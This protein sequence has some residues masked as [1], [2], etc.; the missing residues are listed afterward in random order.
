MKA[1]FIL[2][3]AI[4]AITL[5]AFIP[6]NFSITGKWKMHHPN[7]PDIFVNFKA[8]NTYT[9]YTVDNKILVTGKY[10]VSNDTFFV[11]DNNCGGDYWGAYK[12]TFFGDDSLAIKLSQ[13]S[14]TGRAEG[15]DGQ[16]AKRITK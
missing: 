13:D 5:M 8:D 6:A 3:F 7:R 4:I 14:C 15:I 12:L 16:A 1:T 11:K 9:A 10:K 2:G